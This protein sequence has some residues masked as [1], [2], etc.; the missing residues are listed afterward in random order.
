MNLGALGIGMA[1]GVA[2][3]VATDNGIYISVGLAIGIALGFIDRKDDS[4]K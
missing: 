3:W 1:I 4:D 2:L